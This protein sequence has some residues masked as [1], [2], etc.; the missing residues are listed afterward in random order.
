[1]KYSPKFF[2]DGLPEWK[3]KKDPILS[4]I[5]YRPI[6][7]FFSSFFCE[8][9]WGANAVSYCSAVIALIAC[10]CFIAGLPIV[11]AILVNL[12]LI[13][14]CADGN[15][16]RCVAKEKYGDFA[17]SMSSYICVGLMFPSMGYC[18]YQMGG[19]LIEPNSAAWIML[20]G[21]L[22]GVSDSLMRLIYQ[23]FLNSTYAQGV[24]VNRSEDPEQE[25]GINRIRMKVD[26]YISLGGFL[27][28]V[29]LLAAIFGFLD[30]VVIAWAVYYIATFIA[31]SLYL[32]RKTF[33]ANKEPDKKTVVITYG[34]YDLLHYGH[35][36]M[37]Q[38]AKALGDYLIVALSTDEFNWNSKQKK[39]YFSYEERKKI[40][41]AIS[42]VDMV[43]PEE[44]WEQKRTDV[45]KYNADIF[46][47]G[48]DWAGEFDFLEEEGV[49]VVYLPRTP[50]IS[51]TQI[52][53]DLAE[54]GK[55]EDEQQ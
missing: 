51:T 27:P 53:A 5:F 18:A 3:R 46:V 10:G 22:A 7:F 42:C 55:K 50:E 15:I 14:D 34:T 8:I 4:R 38:R 2:K 6:S 17:D 39:S 24:E 25:S 16:A 20:V 35:I 37:L 54:M 23:K 1:M 40:L 26:A 32:V 41:E 31:S 44:N 21:A 43:I 11:G 52:K 36:N 48:D 13:L 12:W 19:L 30:I 33:K 28:I 29:T 9:G 47:I 49:E 45:H